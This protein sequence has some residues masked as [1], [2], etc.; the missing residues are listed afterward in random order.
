MLVD[1]FLRNVT[2]RAG[3]ELAFLFLMLICQIR[4]ENVMLKK[5]I[6]IYSMVFF[7][8]GKYIHG[9]GGGSIGL[10]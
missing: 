2:I 7:L 3:G 9:L 1:N 8:E 10:I 5:E 6:Q 4:Y